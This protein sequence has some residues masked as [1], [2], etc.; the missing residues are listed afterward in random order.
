MKS[1]KT[2]V[3]FICSL[4]FI[5]ILL[6]IIVFLYYTRVRLGKVESVIL[7]DLESDTTYKVDDIDDFVERLS[8]DKWEYILNNDLKWAPSINVVLSPGDQVIEVYG[9]YNGKG[10]VRYKDCYYYIPIDKYNYIIELMK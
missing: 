1:N 9:E 6:V 7:I 5:F 4:V 10:Y 8:T 3:M 2:K